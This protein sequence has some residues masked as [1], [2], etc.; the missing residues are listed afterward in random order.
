MAYHPRTNGQSEAKN[1]WVEQHLCFYVNHY[2][3][4]WTYYLPMAEFAHNTW[5]SETP[6]SHLSPSS[7]VF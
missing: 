7:L 2:Q 3:K 1:K 5:A 6:G 4:D